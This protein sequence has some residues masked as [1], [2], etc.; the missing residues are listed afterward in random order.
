MGYCLPTNNACASRRRKKKALC[1]LSINN[2]LLRCSQRT[3]PGEHN[4]RKPL[5]SHI[6][7]YNI[8]P[9]N[10]CQRQSL[11][12]WPIDCS[13]RVA[14]WGQFRIP[15]F[16][17]PRQSSSLAAHSLLQTLTEIIRGILQ[18]PALLSKDLHHPIA[19]NDRPPAGV[20]LPV[21]SRWT[22]MDDAY[23]GRLDLWNRPPRLE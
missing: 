15:R 13:I 11:S 20:S 21:P 14:A 22:T 10:R 17:C 8:L 1:F 19:N 12:Y 23:D 7:N 3:M 18:L 16:L 9:A 2:N 6:A 4:T 5:M